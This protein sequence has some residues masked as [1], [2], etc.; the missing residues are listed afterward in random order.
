[1]K[2][3]VVY[4]AGGAEKLVYTEVPKPTM[5]KGWSLVNVRGFG[6][7]RSE[8]FTRNGL[9]PSVQF[10]RVLGIECVGEI[11]E[12]ETFSKGEKVISIMGEMGRAFDGAYAEYVLLPDS[13]IYP[14][15]T[16]RPWIELA[17]IPETYYTAYGSFKNLHI[18][19][20][21]KILVRGASFATA[22][23]FLKLVQSKFPN[24]IICGSTQKEEKIEKLKKLGFTKVYLDTENCLQTDD[25]FDK[26]LEL[27]GPASIKNSIAHLSENGIVCSTGQ[28]GGQWYLDC[29]DPIMELQNNVYLTTF[30][31]GNVNANKIADMLHFIDS[32]NVPVA[33]DK[34]FSLKE[35]AEAH[36]YIES[37][38][39][40]GKVVCLVDTY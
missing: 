33:P 17:A 14:V 18:K 3:V 6:I 38:K 29:F 37:G 11:S 27:V 8:I 4:E 1:M 12:S 32:Y 23:A 28:L 30:Y 10:P 2:A 19:P 31:S 25:T 34:V 13:Q 39:S 5:K 21:D 7:N 9:S 35:V 15:K 40:L 20:E 36:K 24:S 26:I 22:N 16:N